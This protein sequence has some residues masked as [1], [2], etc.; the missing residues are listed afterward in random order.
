MFLE[1]TFYRMPIDRSVLMAE[2]SNLGFFYLNTRN[3]Q[4]N[5]VFIKIKPRSEI[6]D[7]NKDL[8]IPMYGKN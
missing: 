8:K 7:I 3:I 2:V 5:P 1:V 4:L 6:L